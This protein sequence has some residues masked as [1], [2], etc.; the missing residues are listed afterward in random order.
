MLPGNK[1]AFLK[2]EGLQ[3]MNLMLRYAELVR[4]DRSVYMESDACNDD[5]T[6]SWDGE[7]EEGMMMMIVVVMM[8]T[9]VLMMVV[10]MMEMDLVLMVVSLGLISL[11]LLYHWG[12]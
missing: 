4:V 2:G 7:E 9:V 1:T 10:V 8:V 12:Q 3:L 6:Y 5:D 11:I